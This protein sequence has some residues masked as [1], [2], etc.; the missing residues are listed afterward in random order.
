MGTYL[1]LYM[2]CCQGICMQYW[3]IILPLGSNHLLK[4]SDILGKKCPFYE[5]KVFCFFKKLT[6]W[7]FLL[8]FY[9]FFVCHYIRTEVWGIVSHTAATERGKNE[10]D[11]SRMVWEA[12]FFFPRYVTVFPTHSD[13]NCFCPDSIRRTRLGTVEGGREGRERERTYLE[14]R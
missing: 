3:G 13:Q 7:I 11:A 6:S 4:M 2:V 9:I 8:F 5:K 10:E 1:C 14:V 12:V